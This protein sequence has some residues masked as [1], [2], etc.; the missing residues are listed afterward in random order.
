MIMSK[1]DLATK[2]AAITGK[3]LT[4]FIKNENGEENGKEREEDS[5]IPK[6]NCDD[7]SLEED[8][9]MVS[10]LESDN[11]EDDIEGYSEPSQEVINY[12]EQFG[13]TISL[14][15]YSILGGRQMTKA[16]YKEFTRGMTQVK[17]LEHPLRFKMFRAEGQLEA[18]F[19]NWVN[20]FPRGENYAKT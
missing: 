6:H 8:R 3:D 19:I 20:R 11:D 10:S 5:V 1:E 13:G 4:E 2:L 12:A 18:S 17:L 16:E 9:D 14:Y 15:G 7:E